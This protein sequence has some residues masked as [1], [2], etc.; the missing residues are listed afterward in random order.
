MGQMPD[1]VRLRHVAIGL[2]AA[3]VGFRHSAGA[4]TTARQS[5]VGNA[6]HAKRIAARHFLRRQTAADAAARKIV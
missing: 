3:Y 5:P 1:L 2:V 4:L 6:D